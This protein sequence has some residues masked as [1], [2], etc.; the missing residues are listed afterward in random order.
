MNDVSPPGQRRPRFRRA[1]SSPAFRL[2]N[3]DLEILHAVAR[4]RFLRSTQIAALVARSVDR[5]TDRYAIC[6]TPDTLIDRVQSTTLR[7][8]D[9]LRLLMPQR[10]W[11]PCCQRYGGSADGPSRRNREAGQPFIE[12][13]PRSQVVVDTFVSGI[14]QNK[15]G[16]A[17]ISELISW[18]ELIRQFPWRSTRL[19]SPALVQF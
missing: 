12:H 7:C 19:H 4:H 17:P 18:D 14:T 1:A 15:R 9:P 6:I 16:A 11:R 8:S 5:T 13:Q 3:G 2:T 10:M